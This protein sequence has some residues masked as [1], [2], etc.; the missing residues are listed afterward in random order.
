[1]VVVVVEKSAASSE[2]SKLWLLQMCTIGGEVAKFCI[3]KFK[4]LVVSSRQECKGEY[5]FF[6]KK[7]KKHTCQ[8]IYLWSCFKSANTI[9]LLFFVVAFCVLHVFFFFIFPW[10]FL[11][12][13]YF[14][15]FSLFCF[16]LHS[17][18]FESQV[19]NKDEDDRE[20][21]RI[22]VPTAFERSN[23]EFVG[24]P[25]KKKKRKNGKGGKNAAE[26]SSI[27]F[28]RVL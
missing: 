9:F 8:S 26:T 20:F 2:S 1:M 10:F 5:N 16:S 22:Q 13:L 25:E 7:K 28:H 14:F 19:R 4:G 3:W 12:C 6:L 15:L 17:F 24:I 23:K 11:F 21:E 27:L 18:V